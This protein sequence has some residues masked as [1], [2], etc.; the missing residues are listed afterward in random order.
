MRHLDS[1]APNNSIHFVGGPFIGQGFVTSHISKSLRG[2]PTKIGQTTLPQIH[3]IYRA[4]HVRISQ[5][6][7]FDYGRP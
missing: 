7:P 6:I 2:S 1:Q 5:S 4:D 3:D